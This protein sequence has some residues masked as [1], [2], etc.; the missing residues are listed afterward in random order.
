MSSI[1]LLGGIEDRKEWDRVKGAAIAGNGVE[2]ASTLAMVRRR[3]G[4]EAGSELEDPGFWQDCQVLSRAME[5][6]ES[7]LATGDGRS[8]VIGDIYEHILSKLATAGHF[9]QFRTPRHIVEFMV[10]VIRPREGETVLDP[11]CGTAGFLVAASDYRRRHSLSGSYLGV[12]VDRT[13]RRIATANLLFHR[14]DDADIRLGDGLTADLN[15]VDV[16]LANP[17]FAGI[18][19]D[20]VASRFTINTKKTE[21][22]FVEAMTSML[23]PG[24][25]A[26]VIV[27]TS[28]LTGSGKASRFICETLARNNNLTHVIELPVGVFRPYT[29]VKTAILIW[30]REAPSGQVQM[31]RINN[32]GFSLDQRRVPIEAND[33]PEAVR[34]VVDGSGNLDRVNVSFDELQASNFNLSPSRHL[35]NKHV[36]VGGELQALD[37]VVDSVGSKISQIADLQAQVVE[38][39]SSLSRSDCDWVQLGKLVTPVRRTM[40][41]E[42]IENDD[43]YILLEHITAG[44]GEVTGIRA[45]ECDIRSSKFA[46]EPGDILYGKLRPALRKCAVASHAGICSTDLVPLRPVID[47]TS[48][49]LAAALRSPTFTAEVLRLVSGANLP[50][51]NVKELMTLSVPWP[52]DNQI[53]DLERLAR[54]VHEMRTTVARL[55]QGIHEVETALATTL[56]VGIVV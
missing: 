55:S 46:F 17:P 16:I 38:I 14:M 43:L 21:L 37:Y 48:F 12:E 49:L 9:G 39:E 54:I 42:N 27:P 45:G 30:R 56:N 28:V 4:I 35:P 52:A 26:A 15:G 13:V 7:L 32:D 36:T 34:L 31:A 11:A 6:L 19:S 25:R 29:D 50:R 24:G 10:E 41:P 53:K 51:V 8:D 23:K 22:L 20:E 2:V 33:L 47:G 3:H 44:T 40:K 18:V 5:S 1:L